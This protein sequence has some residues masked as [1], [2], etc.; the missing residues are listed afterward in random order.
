M[1]LSKFIRTIF[2]TIQ[3]IF[4]SAVIVSVIIV[5]ETQIVI[6]PKSISASRVGE[7]HRTV[8]KSCKSG[9]LYAGS[10]CVAVFWI[11]CNYINH[12]ICLVCP[13]CRRNIVIINSDNGFG[14]YP[15]KLQ[16]GR[17]SPIDKYEDFPAADTA[18]IIRNR[19]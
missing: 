16:I 17:F 7:I 10:S 14:F 12:Q 11:S 15:L 1:F 2:L 19:V 13:S 5:S 4:V 9:V 3:K 8:H 18:H 6:Q